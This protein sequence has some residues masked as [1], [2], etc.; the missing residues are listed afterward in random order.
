MN[1]HNYPG[2]SLLV[3]FLIW[4]FA[5]LLFRL[6]G[7]YFF[8]AGNLW[9]MLLHYLLVVPALWAIAKG[10]FHYFKLQGGQAVYA[11]VLMVLPGMFFDTFIIQ[12]FSTL[13]PN[14]PAASASSFGAWLM[15]CYVWVLISGI[16]YSIKHN[17]QESVS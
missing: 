10:L 4:L 9:V 14:M 15:W 7:H 16:H 17:K 12:F 5:T 2:V 6:A 3:G 1:Q 13:L 8:I 11:S